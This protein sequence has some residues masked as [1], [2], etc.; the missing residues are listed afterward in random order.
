LSLI[1]SMWPEQ[2]HVVPDE[3]SGS[4]I[5]LINIFV[6]EN[7]ADVSTVTETTDPIDIFN[8]QPDPA[9]CMD[10]I[11]WQASSAM[12]VSI[13]WMPTQAQGDVTASCDVFER[14]SNIQSEDGRIA[15]IRL[16]VGIVVH[17]A[18]RYTPKT[19][20]SLFQGDRTLTCRGIRWKYSR[21][22]GNVFKANPS[23]PTD[24]PANARPTK[25]ELF[26]CIFAAGG[27][28]QTQLIFACTSLEGRPTTTCANVSTPIFF[29]QPICTTL[30]TIAFFFAINFDPTLSE[31]Q[32]L[33][34]VRHLQATYIQPFK[35]SNNPH[36]STTWVRSTVPSLVPVRSSRRLPRYESPSSLRYTFRQPPP[37]AIISPDPRNSVLIQVRYQVEPQEKKKTPKGRAKKRITYTRR[38]VNVTMTGGKRKMNPNPTS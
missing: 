3:T 17:Q 29:I 31:R 16:T 30:K 37:T 15:T 12:P 4:R 13:L 18:D 27:L 5:G 10:S 1:M 2:Y 25:S 21:Q 8:N 33:T 20:G 32:R 36:K 7:P 14:G 34:S 23:E 26:T 6:E 28:T 11:S 9:A 38:F 19:T 35:S 22:S 24:E